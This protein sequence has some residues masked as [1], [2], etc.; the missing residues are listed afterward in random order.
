MAIPFYFSPFLSYCAFNSYPAILFST[1]WNLASV[2]WLYY[3]G[4]GWDFILPSLLALSL[5]SSSPLPHFHL[6]IWNSG[7]VTPSRPTSLNKIAMITA[8]GE[9]PFL[10]RKHWTVYSP[11]YGYLFLLMH[12]R[13]PETETKCWGIWSPY[14]W[15]NL[16][17]IWAHKWYLMQA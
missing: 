14:R 16:A 6:A 10:S 7:W 1:C 3:N 15:K 17:W 4:S 8:H 11:S 9:L 13:L 2:P 5:S 12:W